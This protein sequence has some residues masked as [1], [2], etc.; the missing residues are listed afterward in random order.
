MKN[1]H[2][3]NKLLAIIL[4]GSGSV[5]GSTP[6]RVSAQVPSQSGIRLYG[7]FMS[8]VIYTNHSA[9][10]RK[11]G[12]PEGPSRVGLYGE[13]ELGSGYSAV[14]R[15]ENGFMPSMGTM[16]QGRRLFG[17][18]AYLGLRSTELGELTFG[19]QYDFAASW[20]ARPSGP[21][22]W[23]GYFSHP[24]DNDNFNYQFRLNNAVKYQTAI[25]RNFQ[26]GA[27]YS[28]GEGADQSSHQN[29]FSMGIKYDNGPT[30]IQAATLHV[31]NP[32]QAVSDGNWNTRIFS[33]ISPRS[34]YNIGPVEPVSML[35]Y[36]I[37]GTHQMGGLTLGAVWSHS[38]YRN[39]NAPSE[40]LTAATAKFNNF[41]FNAAYNLTRKLE[42]A[43]SYTYTDI[44]VE[45]TKYSPKYH[46]VN[47]ILNH[48]LARRTALWYAVSYQHTEK[49]TVRQKAAII[50]IFH[51]F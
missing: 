23:S 24:G 49:N 14:F 21:Y 17:R 4:L 19:R 31:S 47:L 27:M 9:R 1:R 10:G 6:S 2:V 28:F 8:G 15:L 33:A 11:I 20:L 34:P 26:I 50:G 40:G 16:G 30:K 18:Q 36:G 46:Q 35:V 32:A 7:I 51:R 43:G 5:L 44:K 39:L 41:E 48:S 45:P 37:G 29:A 25:I 42:L 3:R 13:E 22:R 38:E 12:L